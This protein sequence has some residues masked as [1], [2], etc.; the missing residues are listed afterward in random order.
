MT[1]GSKFGFALLSVVIIEFLA[2]IRG[3]LSKELVLKCTDELTVG[4]AISDFKKGPEAKCGESPAAIGKSVIVFRYNAKTASL[5]GNQGKAKLRRVSP[6]SFIEEGIPLNTS[7]WTVIDE[8]VTPVYLINQK[9]IVLPG[10][11]FPKGPFHPI[12]T[13]VYYRCDDI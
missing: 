5:L 2:D 10:K 13:T 7:V 9:V 4:A 1:K 6:R 8:H 3:V 11:S 12:A